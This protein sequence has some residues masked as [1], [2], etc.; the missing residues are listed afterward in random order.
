E[1]S[2]RVYKYM[3]ETFRTV[4]NEWG[5]DLET[6]GYSDETGETLETHGN[7]FMRIRDSRH[8]REIKSK[9]LAPLDRPRPLEHEL[10]HQRIFRERQNI[11]APLLIRP[12]TQ[13]IAEHVH[14]VA[15]YA[16]KAVAARD[17]QLVLD[18][19]KFADAVTGGMAN[20]KQVLDQ[21]REHFQEFKAIDP[22][23]RTNVD[24]WV[25]GVLRRAT[26][27]VLAQPQIFAYQ[28][29]SIANATQE[30]PAKYLAQVKGFG[31]DV[32]KAH[33]PELYQRAKGTAHFLISPA[34]AP[35]E[36]DMWRMFHGAGVNLLDKV[37]LGP[38]HAMDNAVIT[39]IARGAFDW[40][41]ADGFTGDS[42][43]EEARRR[44]M[45]VVDRTQPTFDPLTISNLQLYARKNPVARTAL[46]FGSQATKNLNMAWRAKREFTRRW[47]AGDK[48]ASN[49]AR[50]AVDVARP[51]IL[52]A[53]AI[54]A[55]SRGYASLLN[56][57]TGREPRERDFWDELS[58]VLDR[59]YGGW[60]GAREIVYGVKAAIEHG[61]RGKSAFT[62][63]APREFLLFSVFTEAYKLISQIT[64]AIRA[65]ALKTRWKRGK[66]IGELRFPSDMMDAIL[67]SIRSGSLLFGVPGLAIERPLR[68]LLRDA[69]RR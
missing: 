10:R 41:K 44:A 66:N 18:S 62:Q 3:N 45:R 34:L 46:M 8:I 61:A 31:P 1:K 6:Q 22:R 36:T 68:P 29:V 38:L 16:G 33:F 65:K 63:A 49:V 52:N 54:Q 37:S 15:N 7:Y 55:I 39:R 5:T 19:K 2:P 14:T 53:I 27:A 20:G 50:L 67:Q 64:R 24:K 21:L 57:L 35:S 47:D 23:F 51:T 59:T 40:A 48:S 43:M 42:L 13:M 30:M 69:V 56:V 12:Y 28:L 4:V 60:L 58:G 25:N 26:R 32:M 11:K 17:A 9:E